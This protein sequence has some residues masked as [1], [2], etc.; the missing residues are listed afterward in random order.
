MSSHRRQR[1]NLF[2]KAEVLG[3]VNL[4]LD[5][6]HLLEANNNCKDVAVVC[7]ALPSSIDVK[8]EKY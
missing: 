6:N 2:G 1:G 5:N 7:G 3:A 4:P 8:T